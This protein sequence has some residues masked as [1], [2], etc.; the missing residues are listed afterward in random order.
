[1][2][3]TM[4]GAVTFGGLL[5]VLVAL[6]SVGC[7]VIGNPAAPSSPSAP[8]TSSG[9]LDLTADTAFCVDEVNRFRATIGVAPLTAS[10]QIGEFSSEAARV[11]GAAHEAHKHFRQTNGGHG[12]ARAENEIPWWTLAR[13]G[14]VRTIIRDGLALEWAE[15]PGG[16]HYDNMTGA[17]S[18]I[19]CGISIA[20]GE[21]T[22]TQDFR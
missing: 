1:M 20:N 17:Y 11:D 16:S 3:R 21:V 6:A 12:M 4:T 19:A 15:G 14:S 18:E 9:A 5:T 13:Y 22:I 8:G 2:N 10:N 7:G